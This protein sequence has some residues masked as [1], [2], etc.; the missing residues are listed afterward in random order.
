MKRDARLFPESV[1]ELTLDELVLLRLVPLRVLDTAHLL[2]EGF[3]NVGQGAVLGPVLGAVPFPPVVA[4][5]PDGLVFVRKQVSE[6]RS[7]VVEDE[8]LREGRGA[9]LGVRDGGGRTGRLG[10]QGPDGVDRLLQDRCDVRVM[11][12]E[13]FGEGEE[14]REGASLRTV[15]WRQSLIHDACGTV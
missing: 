1:G 5:G 8:V 4:L 3:D 2:D 11:L 15:E 13:L 9:V 10:G 12:G 14:R 6:I 7:S